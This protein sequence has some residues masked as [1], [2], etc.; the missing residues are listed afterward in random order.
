MKMTQTFAVVDRAIEPDVLAVCDRLECECWCLFPEPVD[1]EFARVAPYLVCVN[2]ELLNWLKPKA[3]PWGFIFESDED[4]KS[5]RAHLRRLLDVVVEENSQ[6]L[7]LRFYD[8]RILW[9][10]L[11]AFAPLRLNHFL[12]PIQ[13]VRT[14]FPQ[15]VQSGFEQLTPYRP[16]GYEIYSPFP[17][18]QGQYDAVLD[19][20]RLNLIADVALV[21][22]DD[23][24]EFSA[25][26][27]NQLIEWDIAQPESI[28]RIAALCQEQNVMSWVLFPSDWQ[29]SL[30]QTDLS[31]DFRVN[32]LLHQVRSQ[33]VL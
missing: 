15:Q 25:Q 11:N 10:L 24:A 8:P 17:I 27:V 18:S 22:N 30:S 28:K 9:S 29:V 5:L 7:F 21:L 6:R 32:S 33:H 16:F 20:C 19:Q 14:F 3:A 4:P 26:L 23:S 1:D 13:S 31:S 2:A 12:G